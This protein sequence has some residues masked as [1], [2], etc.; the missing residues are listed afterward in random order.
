MNRCPRCGSYCFERGG[1]RLTELKAL[2]FDFILR[3]PGVG[4]F[5]IARH[6]YGEETPNKLSAVRQHI[7]Q[8]NNLFACTDIAIKGQATYGYTIHGY[9][10]DPHSLRTVACKPQIEARG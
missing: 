5:E 6:F 7:M 2:I 8:M 10:D 3:R 1:V 9:T 4:S